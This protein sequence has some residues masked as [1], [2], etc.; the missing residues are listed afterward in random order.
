MENRGEVDT[1]WWAAGGATAGAVVAIA[2]ARRGKI[3]V[4]M[5]TRM[6]ALG[7]AAVGAN[8]GM[9]YMFYTFANGRKPA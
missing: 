5:G 9:G 1:D 4:G 7:G 8:V 6:A 3:P 2:A